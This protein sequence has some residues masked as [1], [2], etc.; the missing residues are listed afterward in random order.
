MK[1]V[2]DQLE[3]LVT[4]LKLNIEELNKSI[5]EISNNILFEFA[6]NNSSKKY[7]LCIPLKIYINMF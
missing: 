6:F 7:I 4:D 2:E 1:L 5:M 3:I